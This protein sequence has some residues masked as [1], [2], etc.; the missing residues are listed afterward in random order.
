MGQV[1]GHHRAL[2][3]LAVFGPKE[4]EAQEDLLQVTFQ[5]K[6]LARISRRELPVRLSLEGE[7]LL[8]AAHQAWALIRDYQGCRVVAEQRVE[9]LVEV[10]AVLPERWA[11]WL[12]GLPSF[13]L[14]LVDLVVV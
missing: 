1:E 4:S 6:D 2:R 3:V 14:M 5:G 12:E 8:P 11:T 9:R 7:P 13:R 10:R